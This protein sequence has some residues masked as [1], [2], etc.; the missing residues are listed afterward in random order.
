M[1]RAIGQRIVRAFRY[2]WPPLAWYYAVTLAI[3]LANGAASA[4]AAF[5]Q[6]AVVVLT[7]PVVLIVIGCAAHQTVR[8]LGDDAQNDE[9][10]LPFT[11]GHSRCNPS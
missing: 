7:V 1:T 11:R 6:H 10:E 8:R 9:L 5:V 3:P 2:L 4:G